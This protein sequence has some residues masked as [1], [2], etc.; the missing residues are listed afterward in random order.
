VAAFETLHDGSNG[1]GILTAAIGAGG[2]LGASLGT[3]I[4]ARRLVPAFAAALLLWGAP[5]APLGFVHTVV[6]AACLVAVIGAANSVEDVAGFTL[7][8]RVVAN[9]VLAAALGIFW[10]LAMAATAAGSAAAPQLH[11]QWGRGAFVVV[12]AILPVLVAVSARR[13]RRIA[14]ELVPSEHLALIDSVPMFAPLGLAAKEQLASSLATAHVEAG[15]VVIRKGDEGD[16][17]YLVT[18]GSLEATVDD[19]SPP[20]DA[21]RYFGEIALLRDVRRTATVRAVTAAELLVLGREDFLAA[22]DGHRAAGAA[23]AAVADARLSAT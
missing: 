18:A 1:V 6:A 3:A 17:F 13:L 14:H 23:A 21:G 12:A 22:L 15:Q 10:G 11:A 5:I 7:L 8:Q 4:D 19:R 20:R 2:L 16:T 9:D